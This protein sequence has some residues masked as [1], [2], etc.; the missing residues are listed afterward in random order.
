V[1]SPEVIRL[2]RLGCRGRARTRGIH[3][4]RLFDPNTSQVKAPLSV[5]VNGKCIAAVE[6]VASPETPGEVT[7]GGAGGK[8]IA[9]GFLREFLTIMLVAAPRHL[10]KPHNKCKSSDAAHRSS[11]EDAMPILAELYVAAR[12][13]NVEDAGT[14]DLPILVVR[15]GP[16]IVFT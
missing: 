16:N 3:N 6:M 13:R 4:V 5:R 1:S 15:R 12:T 2:L 14:D 11:R 7:V 8:V 9:A 10:A